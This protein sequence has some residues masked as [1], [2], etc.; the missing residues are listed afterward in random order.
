MEKVQILKG[1]RDFLP[2][3]TKKRQWLRDKMIEIFELWGFEPMETPTLEPLEL[4]AGQIGEE[5]QLFFRF[6]DNAGRKVALRYDQT[7]PTCR[8]V[9]Q[10]RQELPMPFRRYQIQPAFRAE[11]PQKG[12]YREFVQCD[13]DIFGVESYLADAEMI[14]LSLDIYK[15]LGFEQACVYVNDRELLSGI[16]YEA[17]VAIDKLE[18]IG[19]DGVIQDMIKKGIELETAMQYLTSVRNIK[20]NE[21]IEKIFEYLADMGFDKDWYKFEP[22]LSRS[23][24]YSSGPIWEVKIGG[25]AGGSV[26]GGERYDRLVEKVSG[27]SVAGTGFGMGFDR[28]LEACEEF[29]L[30]PGL[31]DK[32]GVMLAI[33]PGVDRE[34]SLALSTDL[35]LAGVKCFVYPDEAKLDKQLKY[36]DKIN[37][38]WVAIRGENEAQKGV[39]MLKDMSTSSQKEVTGEEMI[40]IC[41]AV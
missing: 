26:L 29:G 8:V 34:T 5:E 36:A 14:A 16:P 17:I 41:K 40:G 38:R 11:K 22:T 6:E 37:V 25:S 35:R 18:K 24:S 31:G 10:Y 19:E 4:F 3:E 32:S 7:V 23:F 9:G 39:W 30:I 13:A 2:A 20:P 28:T 27:V 33:M 12:R 21:K 15:R 1:F